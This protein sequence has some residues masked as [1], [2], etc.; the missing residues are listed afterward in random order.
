MCRDKR[1]TD[2]LKQ[3]LEREQNERDVLEALGEHKC[4]A[5]MFVEN[6]PAV[7]HKNN[8]GTIYCTQVLYWVGE[9]KSV[10]KES[11]AGQIA[12]KYKSETYCWTQKLKQGRL[13]GNKYWV[14]L[15]VVK[16]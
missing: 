10:E 1:S 12:V 13:R 4:D 2:F 11:V 8:E 7:V 5:G 3:T 6:V 9:V 15:A 16:E 14:L